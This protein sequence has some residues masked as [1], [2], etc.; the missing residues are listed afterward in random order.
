MA[1]NTIF[2]AV[3]QVWFCQNFCSRKPI[4]SSA[5]FRNASVFS[6]TKSFTASGISR[7]SSL[8]YFIIQL[9]ANPLVHVPLTTFFA[10]AILFLVDKSCKYCF[11][12]ILLCD[13]HKILVCSQLPS[14][15]TSK[16]VQ[17][18]TLSSSPKISSISFLLQ[19]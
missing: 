1:G 5:I 19:I 6:R 12:G 16:M 14:S 13:G 17:N 7:H 18:Q 2:P 9:R 10:A 15:L 8:K 11:P 4:F 3:R